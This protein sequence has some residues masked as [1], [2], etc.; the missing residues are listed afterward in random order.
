MP[1]SEVSR[2]AEW[3]RD[4]NLRGSRRADGCVCTR[5]GLHGDLS[6]RCAF[7]RRLARPRFS[8]RPGQQTNFQDTRKSPC[9]SRNPK[10]R[11]NCSAHR[12][13]LL[14]PG[15]ALSQAETAAKITWLRA[16]WAIFLLATKELNSHTVEISLPLS[17]TIGAWIDLTN[18]WSS[19]RSST[20]AVWPRLQNGSADRLLP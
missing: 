14:S 8:R 4:Y 6:A 13:S 15:S 16:D 1:G 11:R 12:L 10:P 18:L 20:L 19:L 5:F 7:K 9:A 2:A 17:G 3:A